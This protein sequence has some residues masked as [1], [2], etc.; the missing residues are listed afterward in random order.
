MTA[1]PHRSSALALLLAG[2]ACP[3]FAEMEVTDPDD[4]V[5]P[6]FVAEIRRAVDDFAA[7]TGRNGVCVP[8]ARVAAPGDVARHHRR[9]RHPN[10]NRR[11]PLLVHT[12]SSDP[13]RSTLHELCHALDEDLGGFSREHEALF[14]TPVEDVY[15]DGGSLDHGRWLEREERFA[16]ACAQGPT[17]LA[18]EEALQ[19]CLL[20]EDV[21]ALSLVRRSI[22]TAYEGE[23]EIRG[24]FSPRLVNPRTLP[25]PIEDADLYLRIRGTGQGL[26]VLGQ[27]IEPEDGVELPEEE[28]HGTI[29]L[30][31]FDPESATLVSRTRISGIR[32]Y[33]CTL[34]SSTGQ[35][36][37]VCQQSDPQAPLQAWRLDLEQSTTTPAFFPDVP[38]A[39]LQ[40][41]VEGDQAIAQ[42]LLSP[43]QGHGSFRL[44]LRTGER[45]RLP[46]G[47]GLSGLQNGAWGFASSGGRVVAST[48]I[49][50]EDGSR[51]RYGVMEA[52]FD[53]PEIRVIFPPGSADAS[54]YPA[55]L[56]DGRTLIGFE[57]RRSIEGAREDASD[58]VRGLLLAE[59]GGWWIGDDI[60]ACG[61]TD[62]MRHSVMA[63][64]SS[65]I[66]LDFRYEPEGLVLT[67]YD[68]AG[69]DR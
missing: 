51:W 31:A 43:E 21:S 3:G 34:L 19:D 5:S 1:L 41:W 40:G 13:Y 46:L 49:Y 32:L 22:Y 27:Y 59:E 11:R 64:G 45:T 44:D 68:V 30:L 35:P 67:F 23:Q 48:A 16:R 61:G 63:I 56:P 17:G 36:L 38:F 62:W 8:E 69:L 50:S 55:P 52:R 53:D 2:C 6:A 4:L 42:L 7:W 54:S 66:A 65:I 47:N 28:P 10:Y 26:L 25:F 9:S 37:V 39:G 20:T 18:W 57:D 60:D 58:E 29:E 15:W 14:E 33:G 24:Y 12:G